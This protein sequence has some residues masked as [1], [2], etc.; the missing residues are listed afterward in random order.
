MW[1]MSA[2]DEPIF[3]ECMGKWW[4]VP[5]WTTAIQSYQAGNEES[6]PDL[7]DLTKSSRHMRYCA[8][9]QKLWWPSIERIVGKIA[10]AAKE[11]CETDGRC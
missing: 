4:P 5:A 6:A 8:R 11:Y 10:M 2:P 9:K 1:A 7:A 3:R